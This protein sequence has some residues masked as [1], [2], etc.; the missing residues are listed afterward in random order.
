MF[1]DVEWEEEIEPLLRVIKLFHSY[2]MFEDG[3]DVTNVVMDVIEVDEN[4]DV[5][6]AS[7]VM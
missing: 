3:A 4:V 1:E 2:G 7:D 5:I 6:F